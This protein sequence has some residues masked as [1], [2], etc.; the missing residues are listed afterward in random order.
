MLEEM[1]FIIK[2]QKNI[3]WYGN[4]GNIKKKLKNKYYSKTELM[5]F[6]YSYYD[7][8][9]SIKSYYPW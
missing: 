6:K 5:I 3:I 9:F 4:N 8:K 1:I 2:F 7:N